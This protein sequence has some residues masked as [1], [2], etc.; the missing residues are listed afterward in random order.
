MMPPPKLNDIERRI[1]SAVLDRSMMSGAELYRYARTSDWNELMSSVRNLQSQQLIEISGDPWSERN[2]AY[3]SFGI[4]PSAK[5][6]LY[7][8]LRQS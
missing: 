4:R 2:F 5:E 6:Y 7:S 8:V 1:L 3:A